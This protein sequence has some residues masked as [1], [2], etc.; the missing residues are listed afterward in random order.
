MVGTLE[1][2]L[3]KLI[4]RHSGVS[5]GIWLSEYTLSDCTP[6]LLTQQQ[7]WC[8]L[9]CPIQLYLTMSPCDTY[10]VHLWSCLHWLLLVLVF[11]PFVLQAF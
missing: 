1:V 3:A 2:Q 9:S 11:I 7:V 10:I 4:M 6:I 5:S 8:A